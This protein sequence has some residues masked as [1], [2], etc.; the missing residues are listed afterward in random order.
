MKINDY[1]DIIDSSEEF[2]NKLN[3]GEKFKY[4]LCLTG[5]NKNGQNL[6]LGFTT[7][8]LKILKM[9]NKL[10]NDSSLLSSW[11]DLYKFISD[12]PI[13]KIFQIIFMLIQ[14]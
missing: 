1:V 12:N 14:Q 6:E 10:E 2:L 5:L 8:A 3:K 11:A 13:L 4:L 7:F 9:I